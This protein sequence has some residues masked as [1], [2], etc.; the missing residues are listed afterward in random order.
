[1]MRN[2]FLGMPASVDVTDPISGQV[3]KSYNWVGRNTYY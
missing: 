1:M 3:K 2:G